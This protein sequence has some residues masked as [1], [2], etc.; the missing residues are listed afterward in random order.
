MTSQEFD[1]ASRK[2]GDFSF[3]AGAF[4]YWA[5][6]GSGSDIQAGVIDNFAHVKTKAWAVF[7]EG[8]YDVTDRLSFIA[9]ARYS[10]ERQ[11]GTLREIGRASGGERGGKDVE[12]SG[13]A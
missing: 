13:V 4:F 6:D 10:W 7:A 12:S 9:G 5:K 8:T 11:K 2:F 3:V 1:F